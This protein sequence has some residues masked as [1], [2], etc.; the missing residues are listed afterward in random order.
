[1]PDGML[2]LQHHTYTM[3][4]YHPNM[5]H[6]THADTERHHHHTTGH[7]LWVSTLHGTG[8]L[9]LLGASLGSDDVGQWG[10]DEGEDAQVEIQPEKV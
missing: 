6:H 5:H 9:H 3:H 4:W 8:T 1:M 10:E 2:P 7:G